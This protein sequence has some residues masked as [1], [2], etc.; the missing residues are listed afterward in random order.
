MSNVDLI[1]QCFYYL[2]T[3][4]LHRVLSISKRIEGKRDEETYH[5]L[6]QYQLLDSLELNL[7]ALQKTICEDG[8]VKGDDR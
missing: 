2:N 8:E 7:R 3:F 5:E 6:K 4:K 1:S